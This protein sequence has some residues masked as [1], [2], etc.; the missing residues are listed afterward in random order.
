M[1]HTTI[2]EGARRLRCKWRSSLYKLLKSNRLNRFTKM[3]SDGKILVQWQGL[4]ER[5]SQSVYWRANLSVTWKQK[6]LI[7]EVDE[8]FMVADACNELAEECRWGLELTP[9]ILGESK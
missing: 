4:K 5:I 2:T 6:N 7:K 3:L 9:D 1:A 8:Y